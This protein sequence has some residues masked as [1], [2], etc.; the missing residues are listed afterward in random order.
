MP[1]EFIANDDH[2]LLLCE[3]AIKQSL[4]KNNVVICKYKKAWKTTHS[5]LLPAKP[6]LLH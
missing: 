2:K 3:A 1:E 6:R 5:L 4:S